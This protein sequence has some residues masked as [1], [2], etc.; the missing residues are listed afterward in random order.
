MMSSVHKRLRLLA[1]LLPG[2]AAALLL[3]C[4]IG[5]D[6]AYQQPLAKMRVSGTPVIG[7][8][9]NVELDYSQTYNVAVDVECDLTQNDNIVQ[10]IASGT[11][12][13][14]PEGSPDST[15]QTGTLDFPFRVDVPGDY[16]VECLTVLDED[17]KLSSSLSV[18]AR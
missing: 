4:G 10:V 2:L 9:L 1:V 5:V 14:N 7:G 3:G 18:R 17:N 13:A 8:E 15:P 6:T 16:K 12:P 11:V